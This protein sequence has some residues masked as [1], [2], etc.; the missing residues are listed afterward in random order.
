MLEEKLTPYHNYITVK[1]DGT[2]NSNNMWEYTVNLAKTNINIVDKQCP[3]KVKYSGCAD[4]NP[5]FRGS[6]CSRLTAPLSKYS[7]IMAS[8]HLANK[9]GA[10][11]NCPGVNKLTIQKATQGGVLPGPAASW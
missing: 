9:S 8:D 11:L 2:Q 5:Y 3:Y 6:V 1:P 4:Y 10:T 7:P